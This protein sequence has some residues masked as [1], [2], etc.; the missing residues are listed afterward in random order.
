MD[1][2][3]SSS[4]LCD[5]E[6]LTSNFIMS[7]SSRLGKESSVFF[8]SLDRY[9]KTYLHPARGRMELA[10]LRNLGPEFA[11]EFGNK[12]TSVSGKIMRPTFRDEV[13]NK[14]AMSVMTKM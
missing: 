12:H 1:N 5:I 7:Q 13:C 2:R 3:T 8:L 4:L 14:D 11:H 9:D 6:L 10:E